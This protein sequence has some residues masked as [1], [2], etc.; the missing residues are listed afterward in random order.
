MSYLPTHRQH[1]RSKSDGGAEVSRQSDPYNLQ[2]KILD[3]EEVKFVISFVFFCFSSINLI[4][5]SVVVIK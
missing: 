2:K 5:L 4:L 3:D 1:K